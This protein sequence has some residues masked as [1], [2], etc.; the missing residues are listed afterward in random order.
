MFV[1]LFPWMQEL[2]EVLFLDTCDLFEI[3]LHHRD[4]FVFIG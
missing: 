4:N 2:L 3:S 1:G